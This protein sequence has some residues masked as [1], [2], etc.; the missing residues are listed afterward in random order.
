MARVT[1]FGSRRLLRCARHS[2][3]QTGCPVTFT[4]TKR[5]AIALVRDHSVAL[6]VHKLAISGASTPIRVYEAYVGVYRSVKRFDFNVFQTCER[7]RS[8]TTLR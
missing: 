5:T 4:Y 8:S 1:F 6:R 2:E 7:P 3:A